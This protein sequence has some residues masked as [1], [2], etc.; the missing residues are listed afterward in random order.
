MLS[1][2]KLGSQAPFAPPSLGEP[3]LLTP[4]PLTT[5]WSVKQAMLRDWGSWDGDF[6]A[7]TAELRRRLLALAGRVGVDL[8][9]DDWDRLGRDVPTIVNL[10][11]SGKY[12]MEEFFYAG[13]LPV[14]GLLLALRHPRLLRSPARRAGASPA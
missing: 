11:P 3:Y 6:R 12:L 1:D 4:G 13:G 8:T 14:G 9:L 5:A 7:M 2:Q 10:M